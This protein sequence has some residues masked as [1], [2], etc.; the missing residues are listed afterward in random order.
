[1]HV[2]RVL[3]K[4]QWHRGSNVCMVRQQLDQCESTRVIQN[5]SVNNCVFIIAKERQKKEWLTYSE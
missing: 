4:R 2:S 1:M 5:R 3:E